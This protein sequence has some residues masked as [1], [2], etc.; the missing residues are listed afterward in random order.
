MLFQDWKE[1]YDVSY[2]DEEEEARRRVVFVEN[3]WQLMDVNSGYPTSVG[4]SETLYG[5]NRFSDMAWC[6]Y[7]PLEKVFGSGEGWRGVKTVCSSQAKE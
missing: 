3:L 7:S 5:L 4:G 1:K 2:A 6:V